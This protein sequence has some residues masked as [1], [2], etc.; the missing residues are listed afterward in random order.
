[1][2]SFN[3]DSTQKVIFKIELDKEVYLNSLWGDAPQFALW[4]VNNNSKEVINICI[5]NRTARN[6]WIGKASCPVSLPLWVS[7]NKKNTV[8]K[9]EYK[10][11]VNI[12][13]VTGA[14]LKMKDI[15]NSFIRG[16]KYQLRIDGVSCATPKNRL[17][18]FIEIPNGKVYTVYFEI[19][20]SGD[21]NDFYMSKNL[22]L[23]DEDFYGN[24]QPSILYKGLINIP[25]NIIEQPKLIGKS[26][27]FYPSDLVIPSIDSI[28]TA[29]NLIKKMIFELK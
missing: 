5:T 1:L 29:K 16:N 11:M 2:T 8:S 17:Q 24:G 25:K 22:D 7:Y 4:L 23:G 28:T 26:N 3:T 21:F 27:Q 13:A 20:C 6:D 14:S 18:G 12:D 9:K 15:L 19:N 10:G